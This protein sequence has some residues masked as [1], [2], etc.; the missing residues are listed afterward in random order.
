MNFMNA[1]Q[2]IDLTPLFQAIITILGLVITY[3]VTPWLKAK[4]TESQFNYLKSATRSAVFAAEQL[5]G[6]GN[7]K[8]KLKYVIGHLEAKGFTV[9]ADVI[10]EQVYELTHGTQ[11]I[12][13]APL[14]PIEE[15]VEEVTEDDVPLVSQEG[16]K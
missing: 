11:N 8:E 12:L 16:Y 5:Y 14:D 10:E 13:V 9:D 3:K 6:A 4:L 7:G 2:N 15:S 1:I